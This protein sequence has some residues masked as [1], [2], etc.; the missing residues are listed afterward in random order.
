MLEG[1]L[2]RTNGGVF[3]EF[4]EIAHQRR[5]QQ[6]AKRI[7][8]GTQ[9]KTDESVFETRNAAA[10]QMVAE[11]VPGLL[12][13]GAQLAPVEKD[14]A[15]VGVQF[16]GEAVLGQVDGAAQIL[17]PGQG[18]AIGKDDRGIGFQFQTFLEPPLAQMAGLL[19]GI[20]G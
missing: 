14:V 7:V 19:V 3:G 15:L 18:I 5:I 12:G 4:G 13:G 8:R 9:L 10:G 1:T 17:Q 11:A 16:D 2:L 6:T 20:G